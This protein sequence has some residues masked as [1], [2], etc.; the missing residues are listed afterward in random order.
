[1]HLELSLE[2]GDRASMDA[3]NTI[4]NRV[5]GGVLWNKVWI[6]STAAIHPT[7]DLTSQISCLSC[8]NYTIKA[9]PFLDLSLVIP[10]DRDQVA[11]EDCIDLFS[12]SEEIECTASDSPPSPSSPAS[13]TCQTCG[14]DQGFS[15]SIKLGELPRVLCIHLKRFRWRRNGKQKVNTPVRFPLQDLDMSR[16]L[17]DLGGNSGQG[18]QRLYELYTVVIHQGNGFV[19]P[20]PSIPGDIVTDGN[21]FTEQTPVTITPTSRTAN[22]G[23]AS[24][25]SEHFV[26]S[27][28]RSAR[29]RHICCSTALRRLRLPYPARLWGTTLRLPL[30]PP[31][32]ITSAIT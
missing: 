16:W 8:C 7:W 4:V 21:D 9:D 10:E 22:S 29:Q 28:I 2:K 3:Q 13:R 25:T 14:S 32:P 27:K 15:R 12:L 20:H 31:P 24:T 30:P 5:F 26:Y 23:G 11:L 6:D 17:D 18:L 19:T 1:M